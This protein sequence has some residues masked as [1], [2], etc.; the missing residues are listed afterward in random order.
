MNAQQMTVQAVSVG[1]LF[2]TYR[3]RI[4]PRT[5]VSRHMIVVVGTNRVAFATL[6]AMIAGQFLVY[7]FGVLSQS[8]ATSE[9]TGAL[10]TAQACASVYGFTMV[11]LYNVRSTGVSP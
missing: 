11:T 3:A 9:R 2:L 1:E 10:R 8:T 5:A 4:S 7:A 6:L